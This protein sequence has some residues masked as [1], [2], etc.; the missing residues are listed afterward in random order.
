MKKEETI[1][2][3][4]EDFLAGRSQEAREKFLAKD[5]SKQYGSIMAWKHRNTVA[6]PRVNVTAQ[7]VLDSMR[8]IRK[9]LAAVESLSAKEIS[10]LRESAQAFISDIDNF[11][12]L[13]KN[14]LLLQL[15][16]EQLKIA[17]QIESLR[18]E[19]GK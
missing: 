19:M 18:Q 8:K 13:K 4:L 11:E 12:S 2:L 17:R 5:I 15:E 14:Q 10:R 16:N 6:K 1:A 7:S 3:Y 9:S